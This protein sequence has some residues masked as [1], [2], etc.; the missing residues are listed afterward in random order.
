MKTRLKINLLLTSLFQCFMFSQK[1]IDI[2]KAFLDNDNKSDKICQISKTTYK[3][4]TSTGVKKNIIIDST[5][6]ENLMERMGENLDGLSLSAGYKQE[7]EI[8]GSCCTFKANQINSYKF[9]PFNKNWLLYKSYYQDIEI[10]GGITDVKVDYY[11]YEMGIDGKEYPPD[12]KLYLQD[13]LQNKK[14]SETIFNEEYNKLKSSK[15]FKKYDFK[16]SYEDLY[17]LIKNIPITEAN[18]DKYNNLAFYIAQIKDGNF[19][20]IY[21]YNEILKRFPNR[22]VA[23][24]N[25]ADSYWAIGNQKLAKE[26]YK[27][28]V[29]L[30]KSQNKD[31][32]KI[33]KRVWERIK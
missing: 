1:C 27:K 22:V 11:P 33:P 25:L 24:L 31:L 18:L 19:E 2:Q 32:K 30:M 17:L 20:G 26:N 8:V 23:Y 10:V 21:L 5:L 3:I 6:L 7:I 12:N 15:N 4:L 29:E 9:S 13:F 28:Y 14:I 16:Y